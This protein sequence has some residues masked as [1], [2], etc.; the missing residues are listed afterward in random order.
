MI[1][2]VLVMT[3]VMILALTLIM[4]AYQV[5]ATI[6]DEGRDELYQQ[7]AVSF[8][9]V[10]RK[11]LENKD[12]YST[13]ELISH[14][15]ALMTDDTKTDEVLSASA[16][17]GSYGDITISFDKK[18]SPGN[19]IIKVSVIDDNK[20]MAVCT[21]KYNYTKDAMSGKYKYVF[22]EYY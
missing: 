3:V 21:T 19:L 13:D 20:V 12:S 15:D 22:C 9:D 17:T 18:K 11:R 1:V 14:I 7:Q 6:N 10:I 5:F 2:V 4:V 16:P 8:S